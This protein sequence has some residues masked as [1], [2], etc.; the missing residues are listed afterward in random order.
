MFASSA[1]SLAPL[2]QGG[3]VRIKILESLAIGCPVVA[4]SIGGEGLEVSGL[5]KTDVPK[6]FADACLGHLADRTDAGF[7]ARQ[8]A[9]VNDLYD[10]TVVAEKLVDQWVR[11]ASSNVSTEVACAI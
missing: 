6:N 2:L 10:A 7:R 1:V 4:T 3:G 9:V 8:R 5:T 11:V